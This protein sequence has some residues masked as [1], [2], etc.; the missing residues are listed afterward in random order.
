MCETL[1]EF[2]AL[3][4][5]RLLLRAARLG[6][7]DYRRATHLP[8]LLGEALPTHG[9]LALRHLMEKETALNAQRRLGAIGYCV[10]DHLDLLIAM[11]DEARR[12]SLAEATPSERPPQ[13]PA[14]NVPAQENA[15]G[16]DSFLRAT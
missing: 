4:R 15:S 12:L 16:I 1:K 8:R 10:A 5:P 14:P 3:N 6:L 13:T 2:T 9:G 7:A 11:L